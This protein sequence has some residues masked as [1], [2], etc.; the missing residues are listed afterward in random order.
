MPR[1]I[2]SSLVTSTLILQCGKDLQYTVLNS[3]SSRRNRGSY[4]SVVYA[5]G[6]G[7]N[8]VC[9]TAVQVVGAVQPAY[10]TLD[11]GNISLYPERWLRIYEG[12]MCTGCIDSLDAIAPTG[13]KDIIPRHGMMRDCASTE[14]DPHTCGILTRNVCWFASLARGRVHLS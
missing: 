13:K 8:G 14:G 2:D 6:G 7:N 12:P 1:L 9:V 3:S 11:L 4:S 10:L 5:Y